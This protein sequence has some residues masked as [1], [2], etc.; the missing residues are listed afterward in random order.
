MSAV[1]IFNSF[2]ISDAFLMAC[3]RNVWF[4]SAIY[5]IEIQ[6]A[7][8]LLMFMPTYCPGGMLI[9]IVTLLL[10][11]L[12]SNNP[13]WYNPDLSL[14]MLGCLYRTISTALPPCVSANSPDQ[15]YL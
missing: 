1:N 6:H 9:V 13:G 15:M 14:M 8:G 7:K 11:D 2:K 10:L 3:V 12:K 5:T 4:Y